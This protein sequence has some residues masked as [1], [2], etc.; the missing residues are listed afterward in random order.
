MSR[1][2]A[3]PERPQQPLFPRIVFK[4]DDI[5]LSNSIRLDPMM[6]GVDVDALAPVTRKIEL[7]QER[8]QL[9][10]EYS[11][12]NEFQ[13]LN[14]RVYDTTDRSTVTWAKKD[15]FDTLGFEAGNPL[16]KDI[17]YTDPYVT[18][19]WCNA[20]NFVDVIAV[21]RMIALPDE[22]VESEPIPVCQCC[23]KTN[24]FEVGPKIFPDVVSERKAV[25][26]KAVAEQDAAAIVMKRA[27]RLYLRR[28]YGRAFRET[29]RYY[30]L[31][32]YRAATCISK[33]ARVRLARRQLKTERLLLII[34]AAHPLLLQKALL[35]TSKS[36]KKLFWYESK[37]HERMLY[38]DYIDFMDRTGF[39]PPRCVVED[40]IRE[41]ATRIRI[42]ENLL[43]TRVQRRWRGLL[44]RR[45]IVLYRQECLWLRQWREGRVLSLQ[46]MF[47]G[48][49]ARLKLIKYIYDAIAEKERSKYSNWRQ[50][51]K[52]A[53]EL[54]LAKE[55]TKSAYLKERAL[56]KTTR[57]IGRI[58]Y[59]S[60]KMKAFS[61]SCYADDR[62]ARTSMMVAKS[63]HTDSHRIE[64]ARHDRHERR[65][66]LM[67]RIAEHGPLGY[68]K[69][70]FPP[71]HHSLYSADALTSL[72]SAAGGKDA[73]G[74]GAVSD[75]TGVVRLESS[76][77][78]GMSS[79][80]EEELHGLTAMVVEDSAHE[81]AVTPAMLRNQFQAHNKRTD[82]PKFKDY[83][84]PSGINTDKMAVLFEEI[85][86]KKKLTSSSSSSSIVC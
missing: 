37:E 73:D 31:I 7:M 47:R 80:F 48:H 36:A 70:G 26:D 38:A 35:P 85:P 55:L 77:S 30:N 28:M 67:G 9:P 17:Y 74:A 16:A 79:L 86:K 4:P 11:V 68:G 75:A 1:K 58:E 81:T 59:D 46:R 52:L 66:F 57:L 50:E 21:R 13:L 40:N 29:V 71:E 12:H 76:R 41:I 2:G 45:M 62:L 24:F 22:E 32:R 8:L 34:K 18:C 23:K 60:K 82:L 84:Y 63:E 51:K 15:H 56:E 65:E 14:E 33:N 6:R 20:I 44:H 53:A 27:Y 42:R 69:R 72:E 19:H 39:D 43:C 49:N 78:H 25:I 61:E 54:S 3:R 10:A 83:K 64:K 5:T